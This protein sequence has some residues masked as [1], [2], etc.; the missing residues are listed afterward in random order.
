MLFTKFNSCR[1]I[2][3]EGIRMNNSSFDFKWNTKP[4]IVMFRP[5]TILYQM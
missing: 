2:G 3:W 5:S 1:I 4:N